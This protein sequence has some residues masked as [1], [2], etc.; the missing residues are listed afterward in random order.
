VN[1]LPGHDLAQSLRM[2]ERVNLPV[3]RMRVWK[4]RRPPDHSLTR[5]YSNS[6]SRSRYLSRRTKL[7][8]LL[9]NSLSLMPP[10]TVILSM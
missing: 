4:W 2:I 3:V 7:L 6:S 5:R 1:L 10:S 9:V 8:I